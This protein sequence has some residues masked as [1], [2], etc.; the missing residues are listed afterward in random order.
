MKITLES[1]DKIV[2]LYSGPNKVWPVKCRLWEGKTE[3][4][5][6]IHCLIPSIAVQADSDQS[7]F[8]A[9]LKEHRPPESMTDAYPMRMLI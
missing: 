9:E 3:S 1:T 5:I 4:G 6:A 7:Q 2:E 8:L